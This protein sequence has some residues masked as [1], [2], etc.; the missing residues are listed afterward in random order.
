ML[1]ATW[2]L[3]AGQ[4][5]A[6]PDQLGRGRARVRRCRWLVFY[7]VGVV[8]GVSAGAHPA[9]P[10]STARSPASCPTTELVMVKES[11][12]Q[13]ELEALQQELAERD[14]REGRLAAAA[15]THGEARP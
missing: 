12:E 3:L 11:E 13:E 9:A 14:R 6:D 7:G 5:A 2:L 1:Y 4:L 10:T 15:A 8:F